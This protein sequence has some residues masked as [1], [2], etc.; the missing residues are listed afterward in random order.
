MYH[1]SHYPKE[2]LGVLKEVEAQ[3][4]D[5]WSFLLLKAEINA[6]LEDFSTALEYFHKVKALHPALLGTDK[7]FKEMYWSR[8]LLIEA[9]CHRK[10]K[11]YNSAMKCY[12]DILGQDIGY[13]SY[14]GEIHANALT[15]LFAIWNEVSDHASTLSFLRELKD[16]TKAEKGLS[17]WLG[18]IIGSSDTLHGHVIK[19]AKQLGAVEEISQLYS[20]V[21]EPKALG[22]DSG[23][24]PP[25]VLIINIKNLR[26]FQ[27]A[28]RFHGSHVHRDHVEALQVWEELV[29]N[30]DDT[31]NDYW[32][33]YRTFRVLA[34]ALLD[35]AA[36]ESSSQPGATSSSSYMARL[37]I[38]CNSNQP[39]I[40]GTRQS[41][42]D[43]HICLIRLHL[44]NGDKTLADKDARSLL[45]G[46]FD[47]WPTDSKDESLERRFGVLAQV[48]TVYGLEKDAVAAWQALKPRES[49]AAA[50]GDKSDSPAPLVKAEE[51]GP[52]HS[53]A[54]DASSATPQTLSPPE[55]RREAYVSQYICDSCGRRW[56]HMLTDCWA[57]RNC[58]CVQLCTPC[59]E[60]LLVDDIDPLV[61]NKQH[62]FVYLPK[63]DGE[64]WP[65]VPDDMILVGGKLMAREQW[66]NHFRERWDVQQ[67]QIDA[68]K[69]ETA[70]KM[71]AM[72]CIANF[73]LKCQR[74][75]MN[76][77]KVTRRAR[78]FPLLEH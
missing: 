30:P 35:K 39:S 60:K 55:T 5:N 72:F 44:L 13:E 24:H 15:S 70:R 11:D 32:V 18:S 36:G 27:A 69:L 3:L 66:L 12:H 75:R 16:S 1:V 29:S 22:Q 38:L 31:W 10:M 52:D 23:D 7:A 17:Y 45:R 50:L 71:K 2:A 51:V 76:R 56:N 9:D 54:T 26:F 49:T 57:C 62:E 63:F 40:R 47:Q 68:Y 61:C 37:K 21:I 77:M 8:V 34:R 4:A 78:T 53:S 74:R 64:L 28:L 6:K 20:E 65:S 67:E 42:H 73:V 59:H 19:A 33:V 58:L 41:V 48:L 46:V 25:Q 43:P 14:P